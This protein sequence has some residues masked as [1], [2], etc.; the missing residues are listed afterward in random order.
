MTECC[1]KC[2]ASDFAVARDMIGTRH[3]KCGHTWL[4]DESPA[5]RDSWEQLGRDLLEVG[6]SIGGDNPMVSIGYFMDRAKRLLEQ[7]K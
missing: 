4:P 2:G 7:S 5:Q 3:C 6:Q 1:Q